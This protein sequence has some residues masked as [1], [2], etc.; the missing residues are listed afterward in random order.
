MEENEDV[1]LPYIWEQTVRAGILLFFG[2]FFGEK[3][4]LGGEVV[5]STPRCAEK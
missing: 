4:F 1:P 3:F 2:V 5:N